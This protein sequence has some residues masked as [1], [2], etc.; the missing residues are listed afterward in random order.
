MITR[1]AHLSDIHFGERF[2]P[3]IWAA[4]GSEVR[5]FH[6][7]LLIVSG[8]LVD[9]PFA[10]HLLAAKCELTRLARDAGAALYVVPGNHDVFESGTNVSQGRR[11]WFERIFGHADTTAAE[12]ALQRKL[13][14]PPGFG[15][16]A[17]S[18][19]DVLA[20]IKR[21]AGFANDFT[22]YLPAAASAALPRVVRPD[23]TP[24]LLALL[25][26]NAV[27]Q[28]IGAA[29][30]SVSRKDLLALTNELNDIDTPCLARI[31]VIHH[32]VLPIAFVGGDI[33][34]AE[35]LMVLH[36]A[37]TV[38]SILSRHRFDLILHGHRHQPQFARL[39]L[40]P[41]ELDG[42]P[43]A[44][45]AAGSTA[46][47]SSD[48]QRD[49][50]RDN[51]LN[52]I[53]I[54]ENGRI[55]VASLFYGDTVGPDL[56]AQDA[57]RVR[58][59]HE[60]LATV[61]RR[62]F[63]RARER[64]GLESERRE[65]RFEITENGDLEIGYEVVGLR[66]LHHDPDY[67]ER[68]HE[69]IVPP[70]G[71]LVEAVLALDGRSVSA[72]YSVA[73]VPAAPGAGFNC[74]VRLPHSPSDGRTAAYRLVH[75]YAN[76]IAM[77]LWEAEERWRVDHGDGTARTG[78]WNEEW[79]GARITHPTRELT[80]RL[81][82]PPTLAD[83]QPRVACRRHRD[84]P[85]YGIDAARDAVM[86]GNA[87]PHDD[88]DMQRH[89]QEN[90][91]F[92]PSSGAWVLT[93]EQPMVG[94]V[95]QLRWEIPGEPA[96]AVIQGDVLQWQDLLLSCAAVEETQPR[97][98]GYDSAL[99]AF[100]EDCEAIGKLLRWGG[101]SE[102]WGVE[103]FVYDRDTLTLVPAFSVRSW[104]PGQ[105]PPG[106]R[107]G[108]GDGIAGAAFQQRRSVPWSRASAYSP[109]I[110]PVPYD[111]PS[112]QD[113]VQLSTTL[114]VPVYHADC[115]DLPRP[116]PWSAIG[117]LCFSSS[118]PASKVTGMCTLTPQPDSLVRLRTARDLA[119]MAVDRVLTELTGA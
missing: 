51:A 61:K 73:K 89:E 113:A 74:V 13:G 30:G 9:N 26:S 83:I 93:V 31:A 12:H 33:V 4:V 47:L 71:H 116:P 52:L 3:E 25:D 108:L 76:S 70:H 79:V 102:K 7:T 55:R 1:I 92:D 99:T 115:A 100:R 119:H 16:K 64:H 38:L 45:A 88:P 6:P 111:G 87:C 114:A 90:L 68:R 2:D 44:V 81:K 110:V 21:M 60:P 95:Y 5:K 94:Y 86:P 72:G 56:S 23:G 101:R 69:V 107:I 14:E 36:N 37:G 40:D 29:T 54:E 75:G 118:S 35:P 96:D 105:L 62:A 63:I 28:T 97:P 57:E 65:Q 15:A 84:F 91:K 67:L 106:F 42:Y 103:L 50:T 39:D 46:L 43:I 18:R 24:V 112:P 11:D 8:D 53:T 58:V 20:H 32:H 117:V 10:E 85:A 80:L 98:G 22:A 104:Q 77:T 49:R 59:F 78:G 48:S 27:D 19:T 109:Y 82:L 34:G 66:L 17:R 41:R